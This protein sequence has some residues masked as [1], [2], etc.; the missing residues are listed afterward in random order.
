MNFALERLTDPEIE[1]VTTLEAR[2]HLRT[3]DDDSAE[4]DYIDSLIVAAREM[5]EAHT[6][7]A[8]IDQSWRLTVGESLDLNS[9]CSMH[10]TT[11]TW[12]GTW[13]QRTDGILLRRSPVLSITSIL[14]VDSDGVETAI[15]GADYQLR[16]AG[17]KWPRLVGMST[18]WPA[19]LKVEFRA[20]FA[21]RIGSPTEGAEKVPAV[22]KHA[23][24]LIV[25][26]F[27]NNRESVTDAKLEELPMGVKALLAGQCCDLGLA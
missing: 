20:G 18:T 2:T 7:R 5:V 10:T 8:L 11:T 1:P 22:F 15:Q 6:G 27:Y 4:D 26:H 9:W 14:S 25:G 24:K 21:N 19:S 16:D 12:Y 13:T 23:I 17:A 3:Y